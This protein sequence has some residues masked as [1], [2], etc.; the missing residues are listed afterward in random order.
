VGAQQHA[1]VLVDHG[2]GHRLALLPHP[3]GVVRRARRV[4]GRGV[5]RR[6]VVVVE[7]DLGALGD[8]VAEADEDVLDLAHRLADEVL[9]T[10]REGHPREGD[11][12]AL[13]G[14]GV[15][16][17][18]ALEL[19]LALLHEFLELAAHEVAALAQ[20][21]PVLGGRRRDGAQH[22]GERALATQC[23]DAHALERRDVGRVEDRLTT[24]GEESS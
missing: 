3:E 14:E 21:R 8:A 15:G 24:G 7:L 10:G 1:A 6:E 18:R 9:M 4:A 11:V 19:G 16:E 23:G 22:L 20:Q 17:G 5:E 12:E 13:A 2:L